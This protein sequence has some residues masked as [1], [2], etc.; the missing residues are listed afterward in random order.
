MTELLERGELLAQLE[1]ARDEGGRL[2][3]VGGEAGVGKTMLVRAFVAGKEALLGSCENLTAAT[4]L[5]PFL[6]VGIELESDPRRVAAA[7]LRE[8]GRTPLLVLEDVHW[9]D[10]ATL[11]VLRVLGRRVDGTQA[12]VVATYR[13]DEVAGDHPLRV[14][15]GELASARAVSRLAVPRLSF[16]AVRE[17]AEPHGAD[18]DAIHRLTQGNAFYVTEILAAGG[19]TLPETVRDAVLARAAALEPEARRLLEVVSVIPARAE[20]WLLEAVAPA[21]LDQLGACLDSGVLVA[22]GDGV[23]FRHE[24]ARLAVESAAPPNRRRLVH[25]AIVRALEATGQ[26]S[27]LAHH[28]EEAGDSAAV[29]EYAPEAARAGRLGLV[30]PRGGGAVR[31]GAPAC[32]R[33]ASG[34]PGGSPRRVRPG[35]ARDRCSSG[36]DRGV[37]PGD[38]ALPRAR[39]HLA[40][41]RSAGAASDHVHRPRTQ[42]GRGGRKPARDRA[43][44]TTARRPGAHKR[45]L[46]AG[47]PAHAQSRQRGRGRLGSTRIGSGRAPRR[48][49]GAVVRAE[50][51]RHVAPDGG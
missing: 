30:P 24:L 51:D 41:G 26:L 33:A 36:G 8:L 20:L 4:P 32:E 10:Q 49:R 44:G 46:H 28:A 19:G 9:A 45:L 1:A 23:A 38:R 17:L 31:T 39:R 25:A 29:L 7:L 48:R 5:G 42:R 3:F 14:V 6:D 43:A 40:G 37:P 2:L 16:D 13:D 18:A 27:R 35:G 47:L 34:R 21:E 12:L 11:D 50:H 22:D 15:L